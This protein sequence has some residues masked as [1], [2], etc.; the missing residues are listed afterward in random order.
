MCYR[1][2]GMLQYAENLWSYECIYFNYVASAGNSVWPV[3]NPFLGCNAY[4]GI[5]KVVSM[6]G[7]FRRSRSFIRLKITARWTRQVM[8]FSSA[9]AGT[10][11]VAW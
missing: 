8:T 1:H 10:V 9:M 2:F 4:L 3:P 7:A 11:N 5:V 6:R